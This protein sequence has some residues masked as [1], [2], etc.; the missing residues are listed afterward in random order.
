MKT[1]FIDV[2]HSFS[3]SKD[4]GKFNGGNNYS[5]RA[6]KLLSNNSGTDVEILLICAAETI[7]YIKNQINAERIKYLAVNDLSEI[8]A[9][10]D[11]IYYTPQCN[12][13]LNYKKELTKFKRNNPNTRIYITV[14]DRRHLENLYDKYDHLL[15][16]GIKGNTIALTTGRF[17]HAIFIESSLRSLVKIADK[18]FTDSN[19]SM[20]SLLKYKRLKYINWFYPGTYNCS[21]KSAQCQD[22]LLFVSAGRP[23]KNLIRALLAFEMYVK[24]SGNRTIKFK[25]VGITAELIS[26]LR[27]KLGL[28][29]DICEKQIIF[30]N[31]VSQ[32]DLDGLYANCRFLVFVSKSEGF[33]LPILEAALK[34]KP[35]LASNRTSIPEVIGAA[36]VYVDPYNIQSICNGIEFLMDDNIYKEQISFISEKREILK[37]QIELDSKILVR[38]ILS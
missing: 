15:K 36:G 27:S 22:Y 37:R 26:K 28:D 13:S 38:E 19:Y 3:V 4:S 25:C 7:E 21:E 1:L 29:D 8:E 14:H 17:L 18:V 24:N 16:A 11:D 34:C 5:K 10:G 9:T 20:Q 12:D 30:Y 2:R 23:E 32:E 35:V 6:I 33:G 31:Y